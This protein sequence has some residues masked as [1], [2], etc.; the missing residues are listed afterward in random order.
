MVL[1]AIATAVKT[2]LPRVLSNDA[3]SIDVLMA[4]ACIPELFPAVEIDG[5]WYWD[6]GYGGNPTLWPMIHSGLANDVL[7]VQ[8]MRD[9]VEEIPMDSPGIRRRVGEIVLSLLGHV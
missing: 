4:S 8:L 2:G 1:L 5:E 9:R 6:G 7:V 3:M